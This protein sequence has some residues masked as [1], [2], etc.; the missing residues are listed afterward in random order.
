[1]ANQNKKHK[2][3]SRKGLWGLFLI[4]FAVLLGVGVREGWRYYSMIF[5]PNVQKQQEKYELIIPTGADL[6]AIRDSLHQ[7]RIIKDTS[8]FT[9]VARQM[10][11][12][13]HIHPGR[14]YIKP[15][16]NNRALIKL[17]RSGAQDPVRVVW[18]KFRLKNN[19]VSYIS[20]QLELDSAALMT[21]LTDEVHLRQYG[22]NP[23]NVMVVFIP[24]SYEFY[25]NTSASEF[26]ERMRKEYNKFWTDER[27]QKAQQSSLTPIQATILASIVE[28]ETQIKSERD[29]IAGVY[30]NRLENGWKLQAD[31]T[32]K[33]AVGDFK[34]RRVL[35]KHTDTD[36]P[37]NTYQNKGLPPGPICTP[38]INSIQAVLNAA[39]HEYFYFC[40]KPDFSGEHVFAKTHRQHINNARAF[41]RALNQ[42]KIYE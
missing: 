32:V 2:K 38:S 41:Q 39:D 6:S 35:N 21:L 13:S 11:Y 25:W 29:K 26:F 15:G 1:M 30:I 40:A 22:L 19:F 37:Y 12:P 8:S 5:G 34:I 9:W 10:N 33:F 42:R 4:I 24:N 3:K 14:Y 28:E 18:N 20:R 27:R 16:M 17:L 31:P 23:Q 36:S 7:N